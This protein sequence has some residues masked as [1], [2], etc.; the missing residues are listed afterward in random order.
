MRWESSWWLDQNYPIPRMWNTP[1]WSPHINRKHTKQGGSK[2]YSMG[3]RIVSGG[4]DCNVE[5]DQ[6]DPKHEGLLVDMHQCWALC[7]VHVGRKRNN[8]RMVNRLWPA[9]D[10][11]ANLSGRVGKL[12]SPSGAAFAAERLLMGIQSKQQ[13]YCISNWNTAMIVSPR[14]TL[15]KHH[16]SHG[17]CTNNAVPSC[18][19]GY[20]KPAKES[21]G[22][23]FRRG[24]M[25]QPLSAAGGRNS[26]QMIC[27]LPKFCHTWVI[28]PVPVQI[29]SFLS[30]LLSYWL[31][32]F[33]MLSLVAAVH[34]EISHFTSAG[35]S[36]SKRVKNDPLLSGY[37]SKWSKRRHLL[38]GGFIGLV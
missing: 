23:F 11:D 4:R 38:V 8:F 19:L 2:G 32:D 13:M 30:P 35:K 26:T 15:Q 12:G 7:W 28:L 5:P 33:L 31:S 16:S 22:A 21:K 18:K 37:E 17:S 14:R 34:P 1:T 25:A 20:I 6:W 10:W 9:T 24:W 29:P 3:F 27:A 36:P